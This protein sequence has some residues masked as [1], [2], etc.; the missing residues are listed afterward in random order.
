MR[1]IVL[2]GL[3]GAG[4]STAVKALEDMGFFCVDNM[5]VT[6]WPK[7]MELLAQS[8]ETTR[9]AVV[10]DVRE[11]GFLGS[12][13]EVLGEIKGGE[14]N[15]EVLYIEAP[16]NVLQRRFSET[17]RRHPLASSGSPAEGIL[18]E[19]ELL[20]DIREQADKVIDTGELNVHQ[21]REL[22]REEFGAEVPSGEMTVNLVSFGYRYGLPPDADL[23]FDVR[24]LPNPYF[25]DTLKSL[26]GR[27]PDV[28]E[29]VLGHEETKG[30]LDRLGPMLDFL[31]PLYRKEGKSYL[32]L[33]VGCTGGVHRSVAIVESLASALASDRVVARIRHRDLQK[34]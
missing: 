25:I 8:G 20:A 6:L 22:I 2:S 33:A 30:F 11:R 17:R 7:F 24:F 13:R 12:F 5:P 14:H 23:V 27:D 16:D 19:R 1:L 18:R 15:V 4:K 26:D 10:V 3:S 9:A 28:R 29:F 32:T 21:L 31:L 34:P